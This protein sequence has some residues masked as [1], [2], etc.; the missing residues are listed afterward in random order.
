MLHI[1]KPPRGVRWATVKDR[2]IE[3]RKSVMIY[4]ICHYSCKEIESE[5]RYFAP[6]AQNKATY[7]LNTL[8]KLKIDDI[9]IVS[10]SVTR[11]FQNVKGTKTLL[12]NG[13][14]VKTFDS[15]NHSNVM[16]RLYGR[17]KTKCELCAYL[18]KNVKKTDIVIVYHSQTLMSL[19]TAIKSLKKFKLILE[20][21]EVYSD[22]TGNKRNRQRE[23]EYF[24][25]ADRYLAITNLLN[26][27]INNNNK[28]VAIS[29]GSYTIAKTFDKLWNDNII[30][31]VYAGTF[32]M[33][34]GGALAAIQAAEFLNDHYHVHIL[35][36]GNARNTEVVINEIQNISQKTQA[37][38]SFHGQLNGDDYLRF[39]QSCDIG[40]STQN[41][42]GEYNDTSFPSKILSYLSNGLRVVSVRIPAVETSNVGNEIYYY[43]GQNPQDIATAIM[44]VDLSEK[45]DG[46]TIVKKLDEQFQVDLKNLL[47][48][49]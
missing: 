24:K 37:T 4:Y 12:P 47:K 3:I 35:G 10:P 2:L 42:S 41:P 16:L 19:I 45:N 6:A 27:E 14:C 8:A 29:H 22:V 48:F 13:V 5:N 20:V 21:E 11:S 7:I 43:D 46:R 31:V 18:M 28:P 38:I 30:H 25:I 15:L 44:N 49:D 23:F 34:K 36:F 9:E 1:I 26:K 32:D 33:R 17:A 40:L 39:L